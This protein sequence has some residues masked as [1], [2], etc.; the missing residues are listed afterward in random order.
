MNWTVPAGFALFLAGAGIGLTEFWLRPWD[1]G[2]FVMLMII[3][4]V[5]YAIV[6]A[7]NVVGGKKLDSAKTRD[8]KKLR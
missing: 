7:W 1:P 6:L 5:L 4:A 8:K 3:V 2:T